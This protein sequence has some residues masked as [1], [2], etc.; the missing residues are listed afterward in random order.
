MANSPR[1][2]SAYVVKEYPILAPNGSTITAYGHSRGITFEWKGGKSLKSQPKQ[3]QPPPKLNGTI[4]GT[5]KSDADA[6]ML[7]DSDDDLV[8]PQSRKAVVD[9]DAEFDAEETEETPYDQSPRIA[10]SMTLDLGADV[11]SI[12]F[13]P[14]LAPVR[15]NQ[16]AIFSQKLVL[17]VACSDCSVRLVAIPLLPA[18][19]SVKPLVT[20]LQ[21]GPSRW[22]TNTLS[23]TWTG[24]T[25]QEED[26]IDLMD[27]EDDI[28]EQPVAE[29]ARL[30][31]TELLNFSLLLASHSAE[32][33]STLRISTIPLTENGKSISTDPFLP[34]K[35]LHLSHAAETIAFNTGTYP[36]ARHSNLLLAQLHGTVKFYNCT[37]GVFGTTLTTPYAPPPTS[38]KENTS[39]TSNQNP[40]RKRILDAAWLHG[41][42]SVVVLLAGGEWG[43]WAVDPNSPCFKRSA[44]GDIFKFARSGF[45]SP[46][47]ITTLALRPGNSMNSLDGGLS[48]TKRAGAALAPMTPHTRKTT[49]KTIFE[50]DELS[51]SKSANDAKNGSIEVSREYLGM[52]TGAVEEKVVMKIGSSAHEIHE[53]AS[54]HR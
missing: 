14:L 36:S 8:E 47:N 23:L 9:V 41:G 33:G 18:S 5:G 24:S 45:I 25:P 1:L 15:N 42:R 48:L 10:Q 6:I 12:S 52:A 26:I 35:T 54:E 17:A 28:D 51:F 31:Q 29:R 30:R 44:G 4:G 20:F 37:A 2:S 53:L 19:S 11:F 22:I 13:P 50:K 46:A 21:S 16:P 43:V 39:I 3:E 7:D 32:L 34:S 38:M 49:S 40:V 27:D